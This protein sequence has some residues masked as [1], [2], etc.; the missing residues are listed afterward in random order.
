MTPR[1]SIDR[2]VAAELGPV[3]IGMGDKGGAIALVAETPDRPG[4]GR[5]E[6][7]QADHGAGVG[8]IGDR[9][10]TLDGQTGVTVDDHPLGGRGLGRE[11]EGQRPGR[12]GRSMQ[13]PVSERDQ[14]YSGAKAR[15]GHDCRF[16]PAVVPS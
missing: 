15:F 13:R 6:I 9:V 14:G 4:L 7:R 11:P 8:E 3:N 5:L 2:V 16:F 1:A 12:Q 10:E